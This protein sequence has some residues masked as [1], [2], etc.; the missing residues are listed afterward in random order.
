MIELKLQINN[1]LT[2]MNIKAVR[3]SPTKHEPKVGENCIYRI[4]INKLD[5]GKLIHPFGDGV[6]L[7]RKMFDHY[8]LYM[9][10]QKTKEK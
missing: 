8:D 5:A 4:Y 6:S 9:E 10:A 1:H 3:V 7:G 2:L